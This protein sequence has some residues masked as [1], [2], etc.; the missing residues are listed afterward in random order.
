MFVAVDA[1]AVLFFSF[2]STILF[3]VVA[4]GGSGSDP[5]VVESCNDT[6]EGIGAVVVATAAGGGGK[7]DGNDGNAVSIIPVR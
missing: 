5:N 6:D 7:D 4:G 1:I 2:S 3:P